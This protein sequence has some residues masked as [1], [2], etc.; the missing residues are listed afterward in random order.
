[1]D[2]VENPPASNAGPRSRITAL[3]L[4]FNVILLGVLLYKTYGRA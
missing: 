3:I 4:A 1:M 2:T